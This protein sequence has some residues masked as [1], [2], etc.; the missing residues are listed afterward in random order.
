MV[1]FTQCT[2]QKRHFNN[3]FHVEWKKNAK[4]SGENSNEQRFNSEEA[5]DESENLFDEVISESSSADGENAVVMVNDSLESSLVDESYLRAPEKDTV[6]I[7]DD[8]PKNEPTGVAAS[9]ALIASLIATRLTFIPGFGY[10]ALLLFGLAF[11]LSI[12]SMI[13]YSMNKGYY[14]SNI[15]GVLTF[16]LCMVV[17]VLFAILIAALL[18]W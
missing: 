16:I 14:K 15:L 4:S 8:A 3:G 9:F 17:I 12:I 11:I 7:Y 6:Y 5:T 10:I 1:I 13:R 2:I 18:A